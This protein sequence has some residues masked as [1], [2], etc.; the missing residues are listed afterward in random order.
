MAANAR[1]WV[2]ERMCACIHVLVYMLTCIS[3][4]LNAFV[5]V[6]MLSFDVHY[7]PKVQGM[8][9]SIASWN[10]YFIS[11]YFISTRSVNW[12]PKLLS[13]SFSSQALRIKRPINKKQSVTDNNDDVC[14]STKYS[15]TDC[16]CTR[17]IK[18]SHAI[19]L[20]MQDFSIILFPFLTCSCS[21]L[22][23]FFIIYLFITRVCGI[24]P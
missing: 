23:S 17:Q 13:F 2:Q 16:T 8:A 22:L 9:P 18:R 14:F 1:L 4:C 5:H 6:Q 20:R 12:N 19:Y 10:Y 24:A 11:C 7:Q 3:V 15:P 21:S